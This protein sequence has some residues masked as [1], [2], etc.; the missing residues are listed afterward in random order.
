M[1]GTLGVGEDLA[2]WDETE[3]AEARTSSRSTRIFVRSCRAA[4]CTG[5]FRPCRRPGPRGQV[6]PPDVRYGGPFARRAVRLRVQR[7]FRPSRS[8]VLPEGLDP[9]ARYRLISSGPNATACI[10]PAG[11]CGNPSTTALPF[12]TAASLLRRR[13]PERRRFM[14]AGSSSRSGATTRARCWCSTASNACDRNLGAPEP[15]PRGS[16]GLSA[17]MRNAPRAVSHI[18]AI[19]CA[20]RS[21]LRLE[22]KACQENIFP[23]TITYQIT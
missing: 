11:T 12:S 8:G 22:K 15:R 1:E 10:V 17:C 3:R 13:F 9:S 4:I 23:L 21:S 20:K 14:R 16:V 5:W 2:K 19:P 18:A 6:C 7:A